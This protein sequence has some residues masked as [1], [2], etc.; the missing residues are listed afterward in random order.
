MA[1][2]TCDSPTK[3][4]R[5]A[6]MLLFTILSLVIEIQDTHLPMLQNET[7]R[8]RKYYGLCSQDSQF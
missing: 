7:R 6:I 4:T 3:V 2:G 8:D 5:C 1:K